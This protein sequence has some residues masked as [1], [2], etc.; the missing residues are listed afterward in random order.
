MIKSFREL[1]VWQKA[2][3][4]VSVLY[5]ETQSFPTD[6]VY[7]LT[8]QIRRASVS[9]PSN[10]AEGFGRRTKPDFLNFLH[11][12]RG[13][14]YELQ[15]QREIAKDLKYIEEEVVEDLIERCIE[16]EKLLNGLIHSIKDKIGIKVN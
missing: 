14:L 10:I 13:S 7:G 8:S 6:E 2:K 9:V 15:T 12:A 16:I 11:I 3:L 4:F 1:I 5:N